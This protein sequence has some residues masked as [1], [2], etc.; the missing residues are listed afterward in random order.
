MNSE[1]EKYYNKEVMPEH[2]DIYNDPVDN[3]I[4]AFDLLSKIASSIEGKQFNG[5]RMNMLF[6]RHNL[7]LTTSVP[8]TGFDEKDVLQPS[9]IILPYYRSISSFFTLCYEPGE[10]RTLVFNSKKEWSFNDYYTFQ[11]EISHQTILEKMRSLIYQFKPGIDDL[12]TSISDNERSEVIKSAHYGSA[13]SRVI[14]SIAIID[15]EL[16]RLGLIK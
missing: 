14:D 2:I 4:L 12:L 9:V 13:Y 7:L 8:P 1:E 11:F 16:E 10:D 3:Q 6:A 15:Y 5:I